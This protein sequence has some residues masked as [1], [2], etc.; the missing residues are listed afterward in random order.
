M[1]YDKYVLSL[2]AVDNVKDYVTNI[3]RRPAKYAV[4]LI[5]SRKYNKINNL[6]NRLITAALILHRRTVVSHISW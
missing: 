4:H 6:S 3:D 1:S 2:C 5:L